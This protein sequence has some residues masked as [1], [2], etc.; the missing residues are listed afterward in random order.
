MI[1][2]GRSVCE[3]AAALGLSRNTVRRLAHVGGPEEL[4]VNDSTG[5]RASILD[6][7]VPCPH[8]RWNPGCTSAALL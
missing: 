3:T 6:E 7:H 2:V 4:L 8:R 1:V 5:R